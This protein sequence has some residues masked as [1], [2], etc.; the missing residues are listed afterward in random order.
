[1][2]FN[3]YDIPVENRL[4]FLEAVRRPIEDQNARGKGKNIEDPYEGFNIGAS[5]YAP[6]KCQDEGPQDGKGNRKDIPLCSLISEQE[7]ERDANSHELGQREINKDDSSLQNVDAKIGMDEDEHD[8]GRKG[9][10]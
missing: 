8:T 9:P 7:G 10:Y 3:P 1:L 6:G 2:R 5:R 4:E